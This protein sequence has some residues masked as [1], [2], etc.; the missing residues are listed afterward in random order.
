[1]FYYLVSESEQR[2]PT[3]RYSHLNIT[4]NYHGCLRKLLHGRLRKLL[5]STAA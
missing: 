3:Y 5:L 1:M 2:Q 4:V